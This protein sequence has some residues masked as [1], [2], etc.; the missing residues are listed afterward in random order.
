MNNIKSIVCTTANKMVKD[1]YTRSQAFM[2]AWEMVKKN[3]TYSVA[4]TPVVEEAT[5][6]ITI[7]EKQVKE[8]KKLQAMIDELQEKSKE[9]KES[10]IKVMEEKQAE[11]LKID[12]YKVRYV[13]VVSNR[14]NVT[15]FKKSHT[16][17]YNEYLKENM[18]KRFTV[19]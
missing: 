15:D 10:I 13:T 2:L 1:G 17:L 8:Y 19:A 18:C 7:V 11:E 9:I 14:F 16:D 6:D 3:G 5:E 4:Q 12:V